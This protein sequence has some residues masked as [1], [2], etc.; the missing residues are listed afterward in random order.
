MSCYST[1]GKTD[2]ELPNAVNLFPLSGHGRAARLSDD[3][4]T[5]HFVLFM[6]N[7]FSD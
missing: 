4:M 3:P 5:A 2:K 6:R 7:D 1:R